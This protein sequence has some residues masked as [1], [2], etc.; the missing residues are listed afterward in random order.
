MLC[1][2]GALESEA[3]TM[4]DCPASSTGGG[5]GAACTCD[6]GYSGEIAWDTNTYTGS[7]ALPDGCDTS[8]L[9]IDNSDSNDCGASVASGASC[10][11]TC[12][13][14]YAAPGEGAMLC[15]AGVLE[16]ATCD[17]LPCDT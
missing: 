3:C 11:V 16:P 17:P 14:G 1:T 6:E 15:T 9:T 7:C 8:S 4:V 12:S 5:V 2:A 13:A 10:T